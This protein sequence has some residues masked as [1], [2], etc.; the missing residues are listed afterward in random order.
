MHQTNPQFVPKRNEGLQHYPSG[1]PITRESFSAGNLPRSLRAPIGAFEPALNGLGCAP[2]FPGGQDAME[3]LWQVRYFKLV[4][5]ETRRRNFQEV[6]LA[7]R[8]RHCPRRFLQR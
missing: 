3:E 7:E 1:S 4:F 6:L 5:Q 2:L 8:E